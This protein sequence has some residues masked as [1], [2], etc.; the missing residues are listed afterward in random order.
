MVSIERQNIMGFDVNFNNNKPM[1]QEAQSMHDDGGAGNLGYFED[2]RKKKKSSEK[3]IFTEAK[4]KEDTFEKHD[5]N[6]SDEESFSIAAF[7]AKI[8][9]NIKDWF[10]KTVGF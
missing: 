2:D 7:I 8:I 10:K 9:L 3:S 5:G 1:I 4:E 6:S